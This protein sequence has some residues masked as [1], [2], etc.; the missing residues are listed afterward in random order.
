M[1][2]IQIPP[3]MFADIT[4]NEAQE[5]RAEEASDLVTLVEEIA[6][7]EPRGKSRLDLLELAYAVFR[8][9]SYGSERWDVAHLMCEVGVEDLTADV[10]L[11]QAIMGDLIEQ[12]H[13]TVWDTIDAVA[14]RFGGDA[15]RK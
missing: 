8:D 10:P 15:L 14:R 7:H 4:I 3:A 6:A 12:V 11:A 13:E 5:I 2:E 1:N 9:A